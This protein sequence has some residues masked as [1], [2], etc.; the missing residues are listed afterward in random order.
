MLIKGGRAA[1]PN[2]MINRDAEAPAYLQLAEILR[3]KILSGLLITSFD[4]MR[5]T[6]QM[7]R[8]SVDPQVAR[9]PIIVGGGTMNAKVCGI[10]GADFWAIDALVG[11]ELCKQ[12][13][14]EQGA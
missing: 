1:R 4:Y 3:E 14:A 5:A 12:I 6:V 13:M 7:L 2:E 8:Q 10:I 11:T 9:I